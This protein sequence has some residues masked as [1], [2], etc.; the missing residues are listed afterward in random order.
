[1][2]EGGQPFEFLTHLDHEGT[3]YEH[4]IINPQDQ[5]HH[6]QSQPIQRQQPQHSPLKHQQSFNSVQKV[7]HADSDEEDVEGV[8]AMTG[9]G[10][11]V[12]PPKE[13]SIQKHTT[14]LRS[15]LFAT[16]C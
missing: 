3:P 14:T 8:F 1:M 10:E 4:D 9:I 13:K 15:K 5:Q 12:V 6:R 16:V 7:D 2:K 11:D